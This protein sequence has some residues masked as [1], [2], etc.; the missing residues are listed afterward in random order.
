[1]IITL[2]FS[3]AERASRHYIFSLN[4]IQGRLFTAL[5]GFPPF[6]RPAALSLRSF[7]TFYCSRRGQ[8][9][10]ARQSPIRFTA[11][12]G[13]CGP[14]IGTGLAKGET[15]QANCEWPASAD[16]LSNAIP[17]FRLFRGEI[18][19]RLPERSTCST[20]SALFRPFAL[21]SLGQ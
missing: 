2:V 21:Q 6:K 18:R 14:R 10:G 7:T 8:T 4:L 9:S 19:L 3:R 20:F 12:S 16:W 11:I 13:S 5:S 17:L 15:G 1:M